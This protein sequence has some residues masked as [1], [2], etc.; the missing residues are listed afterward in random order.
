MVVEGNS[1]GVEEGLYPGGTGGGVRP[2]VGWGGGGEGGV[3]DPVYRV[4]GGGGGGG[5]GMEEGEDAVDA[6][7]AVY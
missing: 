4:A 6:G 5:E 2:D 1:A 3:G 7:A